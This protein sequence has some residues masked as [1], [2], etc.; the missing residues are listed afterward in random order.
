MIKT[1]EIE[2]LLIIGFVTFFFIEAVSSFANYLNW[3]IFQNISNLSYVIPWIAIYLVVL[4]GEIIIFSTK[5]VKD[6]LRL[7]VLI[8]I[9]I[10][11]RVLI[12]FY[13]TAELFLLF[14][15]ALFIT[16]PITLMELFKLSMN[17][18]ELNDYR[19][20]IGG[21]LIGF[22]I[23]LFFLNLLISSTLSTDIMKIP[24]IFTFLALLVIFNQTIFNPKNRVVNENPKSDEKKSEIGVIKLF[25][26]GI[27][28]YLSITWIFNPMA[29]AA[30]DV[31]ILYVV[32]FGF[33]Y[34]SLVLGISGVVSFF[35]VSKNILK[36]NKDSIKKLLILLNAIYAGLNCLT[37]LFLDS[38]ATLLSTIYLTI[39][40][41]LGVLTII[42]D[43][44]YLFHYY[45]LPTK[46]KAFTGL[47]A[48]ILGF[49]ASYA[50]FLVVSWAVYETML[51]TIFTLSLVF[52]GLFI[53]NELIKI[54]KLKID[55]RLSL[56]NSKPIG[57]LLLL[58]LGFNIIPII[59]TTLTRTYA[60]PSE[61]NPII[62]TWNIH[63]AGGVDD[64][65]DIDRIV[66]EIKGYDPDI[67][68]LN[69]VD[70][71]AL[72]TGFIDLASYIAYKLNMYFY[73]GP[74]FIKHYGNAI[75]SKY[76]F[77][78]VEN[79]GLPRVLEE[80]KEPRAV[81]KAKFAINS[82]IWTVYVNH[83]NT[84]KYDRLL[85]VPFIV[86]KM[87]EE[88]FENVIW[89]GDFNF[90]PNSEEYSLINGTS[91]LKFRDTHDFLYDPPSLTGGFDENNQ[92]TNII[93]YI[94]CSPDLIP[95]E[96][97]VHCSLASDHCAVITKF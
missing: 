9:I 80:D 71:G 75:L 76:P 46:I 23:H 56:E 49:A 16:S 72:K 24:F 36:N 2:F 61:G 22:G 70:M 54:G 79:I 90:Q 87:A 21:L 67:L 14:V 60:T 6:T 85:Q 89:M 12:Q 42:F 27:L 26:F 39:L 64:K 44:S 18:E 30:Y 95:I 97:I 8:F 52:F 53:L 93:D 59:K 77:Y 1:K 83:L 40:T 74:T 50:I 10:G 88:T 68:G 78:S 45:S 38:D 65:F 92:P 13:I 5:L 29:I 15:T 43:L 11:L 37:I 81:I 4:L 82:E 41:F 86:N 58:L 55:T 96:G 34:Y 35:L 19:L 7:Y 91:T 32:P 17:S 73:Y 33:L 63:N 51:W 66:E 3:V 69:E 28:F 48:F 94:F 57:F 20:N 47:I 62:M 31:M 25:L 84:K